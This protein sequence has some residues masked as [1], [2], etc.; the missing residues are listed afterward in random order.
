MNISIGAQDIKANVTSSVVLCF[1]LVDSK[2]TNQKDLKAVTIKLCSKAG[3][4]C[5][6]TEVI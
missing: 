1:I 5:Y 4:V 2:Q 3:E 6:S